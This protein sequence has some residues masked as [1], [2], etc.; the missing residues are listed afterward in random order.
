MEEEEVRV[1]VVE[2]AGKTTRKDKTKTL[3]SISITIL[4]DLNMKR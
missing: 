1:V 2:V 3:G 4:K